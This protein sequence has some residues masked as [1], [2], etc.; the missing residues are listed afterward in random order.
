MHL[1]SSSG[2]RAFDV[3][4]VVDAT[5]SWYNGGDEGHQR[6]HDGLRAVCADYSKVVL[7]GDSMGAAACMLFAELATAVVAF[8]PQLHLQ[9]SSIRPCESEQWYQRY[10]D[11]VC[12]SLAASP[13]DIHVRPRLVTRTRASADPSEP[14]SAPGK[15]SASTECLARR[16]CERTSC[17]TAAPVSPTML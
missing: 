13:A 6:W 4:F 8:C 17:V 9:S 15:S 7:L 3:C 10:H 16:S 12:A 2:C 5:R 1:R 14:V 11:R